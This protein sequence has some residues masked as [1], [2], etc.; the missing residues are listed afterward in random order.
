[1]EN[2]G[3]WL[4]EGMAFVMQL[5]VGTGLLVLRRKASGRPAFTNDDRQLFFSHSRLPLS[6]P[7]FWINFTLA[8]FLT[9]AIG[10]LEHLL[11]AQLGASILATAQ[12]L[13]LFAIVKRLLC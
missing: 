4:W 12:L 8:V 6:M 5:C 11:L 10:L 1:M 13:T 9:Y 2:S 7:R 3:Y